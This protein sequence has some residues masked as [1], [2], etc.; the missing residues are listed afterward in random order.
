MPNLA[1]NQG[2]ECTMA[3]AFAQ[4]LEI[5]SCSVKCLACT[6]GVK[7]LYPSHYVNSYRRFRNDVQ[8]NFTEPLSSVSEYII[9]IKYFVLYLLNIVV[10]ISLLL[11]NIFIL[12]FLI[13]N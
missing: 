3:S 2:S 8:M 9:H 6:L 11:L 12:F 1:E 5:R 7:A 4:E 10:Q 13:I